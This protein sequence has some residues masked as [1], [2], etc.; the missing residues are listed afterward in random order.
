MTLIVALLEGHEKHSDDE[1]N[2]DLHSI[3]KKQLHPRLGILKI[4]RKLGN[5]DVISGRVQHP[6]LY[7]H[8]L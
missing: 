5:Y 7:P 3:R 1:K 6:E 8:H 2:G 4:R